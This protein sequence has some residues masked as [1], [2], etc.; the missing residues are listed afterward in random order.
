MIFDLMM[1]VFGLKNGVSPYSALP[2]DRDKRTPGHHLEN[3]HVR[4]PYLDS[5]SSPDYLDGEKPP[6]SV[7]ERP[8]HYPTRAAMQETVDN[9]VDREFDQIMGIY[10]RRPLTE[11]ERGALVELERM[12]ENNRSIYKD[13]TTGLANQRAFEEDTKLLADVMGRKGGY[14]GLVLVDLEGSGKIGES[15]GK[16]EQEQM[17]S[18][19][20]K[21]VKSSKLRKSDSVYRC[22]SSMYAVLL[23]EAD[24]E[25]IDVRVFAMNVLD[26][27]NAQTGSICSSE[28]RPPVS[29]GVATIG[30]ENG[31]LDTKALIREATRD[32]IFGEYG[33]KNVRK[34]QRERRLVA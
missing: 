30:P 15:R 20:G 9:L 25:G 33:K 26:R 29:I 8:K 3:Q 5:A 12:R 6:V 18:T 1:N 22:G 34:I 24:A 7:Q 32:L 10:G 2:Q 31:A 13:Q 28:Y 16:D 14:L 11:E 17:F 23:P 27:I 21:V 4:V 19:T